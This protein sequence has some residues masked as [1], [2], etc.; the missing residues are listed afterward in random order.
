M[1]DRL[2]PELQHRF[3]AL[4]RSEKAAA[5]RRM[6]LPLSLV[7]YLVCLLF[8]AFC[9]EGSDWPGYGALF[10]GL[11]GLLAPSV[12]NLTWLANPFLFGCWI[13]VLWDSRTAAIYLGLA[14]MAFSAMFLV[15][16][17]VVGEKGHMDI[18]CFGPGYWLWLTSI[19]AA[20]ISAFLIDPAVSTS[21]AGLEP[22]ER[23]PV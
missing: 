4:I 5:T 11:G 13:A 10:L 15:A 21:A 22:K 17:T 19:A 9:I 14:A 8:N 3:A 23:A 6:L 7:L 1:I 18:T 12:G 2:W 20:S 16:G